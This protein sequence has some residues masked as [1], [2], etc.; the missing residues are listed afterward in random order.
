M[1][2]NLSYTFFS[3]IY[4]RYV[5]LKHSVFCSSS[6]VIELF[7][8]SHTYMSDLFVAQ[9]KVIRRIF[10]VPCRTD[11]DIVIKLGPWGHNLKA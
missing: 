1:R 4:K 11:N 2:Q 7:N 3:N 6:F 5:I 10:R 8:Y 9:R